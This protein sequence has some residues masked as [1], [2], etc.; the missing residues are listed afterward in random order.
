MTTVKIT[1][2][3]LAS[4]L[5][6]KYK[7]YLK[8]TGQHGTTSQYETLLSD[9]ARS[10][11]QEATKRILAQTGNAEVFRHLPLTYHLLKQGAPLYP[12][13]HGRRQ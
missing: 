13:Y 6:C 4:Y 7:A 3:V 10:L 12:R 8:M 2:D 11:T 5:S 1:T 9:I